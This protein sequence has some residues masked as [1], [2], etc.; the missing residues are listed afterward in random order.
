M[1]Y[2]VYCS[3]VCVYCCMLIVFWRWYY[4]CSTAV[5]SSRSRVVLPRKVCIV[6]YNLSVYR[7]ADTYI[8][9]YVVAWVTQHT[10][11]NGSSFTA[12]QPQFAPG[13]IF[14]L[15]TRMTAV[16]VFA[17]KNNDIV[18]QLN[19]STCHFSCWTQTWATNSPLWFSRLYKVVTP[20]IILWR[21]QG[22]RKTASV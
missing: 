4:Y 22:T 9:T 21:L 18:V 12:Y 7:N 10:H 2:Q 1:V 17:L 8:R 13:K 19:S 3:R 15:V 11:T 16:V 20:A 6:P 14:Y 5:Q